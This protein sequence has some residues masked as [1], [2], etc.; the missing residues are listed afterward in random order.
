MHN[1]VD[2]HIGS[3]HAF[4]SGIFLIG[5]AALSAF[6]KRDRWLA[7]CRVIS[8]CAGVIL[9]AISSTPLPIWLY[10]SAGAITLAWLAVENFTKTTHRH[11][12]LTLRYATLAAGWLGVALELPFHLMPTIPAL[13]DAQVFLVGDSLSAGINR[14]TETWPRLFSRSHHVVLH[15][16]S[17]AGADVATA[18]LQAKQVTGPKSLVLAEIGGNDVLRANRPEAFEEGLDLLLAKLRDDG[19]TVIMFE[20]PLPPF[21]NRYGKAQRR[22]AKRHDVLLIPKRVLMGV[23]TTDGATVDGIHLSARGHELLAET[24]WGIIGRAISR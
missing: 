1:W 14:E 23:L 24:V 8:A 22:L 3:G 17:R 20:L 5:L 19:Q 10:A 6:L 4:F 7:F 9:V 16:L 13:H 11:L 12:R 2:Y 15:D 21:H 18:M